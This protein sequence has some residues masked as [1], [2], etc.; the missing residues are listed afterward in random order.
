[1]R[2]NDGEQIKQNAS[3]EEEHLHFSY[4]VTVFPQVTSD[5]HVGGL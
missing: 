3:R 1:M 4:H 2:A 5:G